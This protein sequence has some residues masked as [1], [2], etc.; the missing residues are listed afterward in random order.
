MPWCDREDE[1]PVVVP[2]ERLARS[3][4]DELERVRELPEHPPQAAE[5]IVSPGGP[6]T[7]SGTSRWRSWNVFSIPGSPR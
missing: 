6:Y 4:L 3:H 2:V 5:Q 7:V 1:D